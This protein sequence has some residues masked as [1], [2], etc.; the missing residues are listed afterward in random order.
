MDKQKIIDLT[1]EDPEEMFGPNWENELIGFG[2]K[3]DCSNLEEE[4]E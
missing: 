3:E 4:T 2:V 1:G